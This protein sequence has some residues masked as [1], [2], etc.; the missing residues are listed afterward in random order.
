MSSLVPIIPDYLFSNELNVTAESS[1]YGPASLSPLQ[2]KYE[3]LEDDNGPLGALLASK[4]FVQLAFT[5]VMGYLTE[6]LGCNIPLLIGSCNMLFASV[7]FAYGNSYGILVLARALHGSSS[8][9][10]AVSGMCILA[11]HL[12]KELRVKLMPLSFGGIALGV[13]IGYPLGGAAY[14]LLGKAAPF[15]FIGFFVAV[16][17]VL[18]VRYLKE[19][20]I[21]NIAQPIQENYTEWVSLLKDKQ[22]IIT[23]ISICACTSTMA[24][25][26]PCV[27]MCVGYFIGS[28]FAAL[29]PVLPWRIAISGMVLAGLSCCALPLSNSIFQLALPH[30]GIGLGVGALDAA[31]VPMLA[32]FVDNKGSTHYGPVYALQ[33]ASV[34]VAYSFGPLLG[35]Q[36]VHYLGFPWLIRIVGFMNLLVCPLLLELD[37]EKKKKIIFSED[38]LPSYSSIE[39]TQSVT[40]NSWE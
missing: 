11:K 13:L 8:A 7:L 31:L 32:S 25:L 15:L 29:L 21:E 22:I 10:I 5:P 33:Q 20:D 2:R 27:P 4:A 30:F 14:Q 16:N 9:A 24:V 18:Q 3:T 26:E 17:I 34:A 6:I 19:D 38:Q 36:A 1:R 39:N 35:G 40:Q 23:A 12:P 37:L 28:H